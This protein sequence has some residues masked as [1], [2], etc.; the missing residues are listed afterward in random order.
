MEVRQFRYSAD[1]LAYVVFGREMCIAVDGG[2]TEDILLFLR[3][4]GLRLDIVTNT[5]SHGDHTCGNRALLSNS[6]ARYVPASELAS[7][8]SLD[9][10]GAALEIVSTPG[11]TADSVCLLG[12]GFLLSGDTLF[13]GKVGRCFTGDVK[14]LFD[15]IGKLLELPEG[16]LVLGGHDYVH[17]YMEFARM[18][19]PGNA[20]IDAYLDRYDPENLSATLA[21]EK[22]VD[23]FLRL[24]EPDVVAFL[25]V[26]GLPASSR[27]QRFS[28]LLTL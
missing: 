25:E 24:E 4:R 1:N 3:N 13:N 28:S 12:E 20:S 15:S 9:V 10:E 23:P 8:G 14:G 11:H 19:E 26:R 18:I 27:F 7:L 22:G 16:T 21:Q 2:A 17:E 5:H 6:D